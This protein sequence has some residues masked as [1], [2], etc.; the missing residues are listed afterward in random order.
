MV[1]KNL[2]YIR[3]NILVKNYINIINKFKEIKMAIASRQDLIDYGLRKLGYPVIEVNIED[4]QLNDCIDDA[5]Q[6][7]QEYHYDSYE[8]TYV[9]RQVTASEITVSGVT[10]TFQQNEW[11]ISSVTGSRF[12]V[13]QVSLPIIS[14]MEIIQGNLQVAEVLTGEISGATATVS[15]IVLSDIQNGFITL[16]DNIHG[17]TKLLPW[18]Q[19]NS[20]SSNYMFNVQYQM[21][22]NDFYALTNSNLVYYTQTMTHLSMMEQILVSQPTLRFNRHAGRVYIDADIMERIGPEG[23]I[24]LECYGLLDPD[25]Y[26]RVYN[27]R[28]LKRL[29]VAYMK[30]QWGA[31]LSKFSDILLPGGVKLRG[32]DLY[33]EAQVEIADLERDFQDK[34]EVPA[35]FISG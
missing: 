30:R 34:F 5:F 2:Y 23:W 31:N 11:V 24:I 22:L 16:P 21:R 35:I 6:F 8:K 15:S 19:V 13:Y 25:V 29:V 10:G 17:V 27:D 14:T 9:R 18:S 26:T 4:T 20:S 12:R 1:L 28:M 32:G 3:K 7:Y 33:R